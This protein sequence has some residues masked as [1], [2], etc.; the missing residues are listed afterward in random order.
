MAASRG[1]IRYAA[2]AGRVVAPSAVCTVELA[3]DLQP[4]LPAAWGVGAEDALLRAADRASAFLAAGEFVE[5]AVGPIDF[6][7]DV[8]C[9]LK[10]VA[11]P[12]RRAFRWNV[13]SQA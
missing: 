1:W 4:E 10:P 5:R 8:V 3:L 2:A 12:T 9:V 13:R 6:F 7:D 11:P